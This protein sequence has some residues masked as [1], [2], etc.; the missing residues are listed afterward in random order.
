MSATATS[1]PLGSVDALPVGEGRVFEVGGRQIAVFRC[2]SGA[3]H[4]TDAACPHR[5][6][7]LADGLVGDGSVVCP[8][9]GFVFDLC[10]GDVKDR[11]CARLTTYP[12]R[13]LATGHVEVDLA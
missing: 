10:T 2:R 12:V 6:G 5:G 11:E 1:F 13:V 3:L 4:A 9:H 7:P 8:L